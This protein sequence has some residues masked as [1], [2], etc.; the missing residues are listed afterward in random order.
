MKAGLLRTAL[1]LL[2]TPALAAQ[3]P[4]LGSSSPASEWRSFRGSVHQTGLS[5]SAPP[6]TLKVLWTYDAGETVESTAA[7]ADGVVYVGGG[8]GDL[9]ALDLGSG[10]VRWKYKTANNLIGESSPA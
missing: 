8:D 3:Q 5:D 1:L 9:V 6:A 2:V 4:D 10:A 7:I